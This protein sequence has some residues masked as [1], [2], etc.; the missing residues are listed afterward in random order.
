[1]AVAVADTVGGERPRHDSP[2]SNRS[3]V[4]QLKS[5]T[6]PTMAFP[7]LGPAR[8]EAAVGTE[9]DRATP[10]TSRRECR[11][12]AS[13]RECWP[14]ASRREC[15]PPAS[16][17]RTWHSVRDFG[18]ADLQ[19]RRNPSRR[20]V[21]WAIFLPVSGIG[22]RAGQGKGRAGGT[23]AKVGRSLAGLQESTAASVTWS[24]TQISG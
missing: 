9:G 13:R 4:S 12:P 14:P 17:I 20:A 23:E 18:E 5:A 10:Q 6:T 24:Q 11:P 1:M 7:T 16:R 22:K 19:E 8:M 15:R 21:S 3:Q 2:A